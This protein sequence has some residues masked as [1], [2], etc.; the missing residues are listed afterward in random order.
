MSQIELKRA[1]ARLNDTEWAQKSLTMRG[2]CP[3][4]KL[5]LVRIFLC[6]YLDTFHAV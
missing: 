3:N 2:K 6:S 4:V 1:Q 5:F